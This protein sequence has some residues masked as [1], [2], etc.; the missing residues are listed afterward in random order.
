MYS[1]VAR[2]VAMVTGVA[3]E[4]GESQAADGFRHFWRGDGAADGTAVAHALGE[5]HNVG[6]HAP[7]FNA[8]PLAAGAPPAGLHFVADEEVRRRL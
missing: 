6:F 2:V 7:V 3:A 8:E 1:S 4:S 5:G